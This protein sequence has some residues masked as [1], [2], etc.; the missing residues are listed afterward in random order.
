MYE[1]CAVI[2]RPLHGNRKQSTVL[3]YEDYLVPFA[4]SAVAMDDEAMYMF[5]L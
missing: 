5:L 2:I 1:G 3:Y 4:I